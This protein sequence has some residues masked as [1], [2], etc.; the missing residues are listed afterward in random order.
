MKPIKTFGFVALAALLAMAFIG[1][2]SAVAEETSLCTIDENPCP[3]ANQIT[4]IHLVTNGKIIVLSSSLNVECDALYLGPALRIIVPGYIIIH[5]L[6][7]YS[8]CNNS[9]TVTEEN[10]P[11]EI[12]VLKEGHE[13]AKVT[14]EV[15][16]HLV[17]SGFINCR[18]NGVGLVGTA[19]GPLLSTN[20]LN[21]HTIFSEKTINKESGS[22]CPSTGKL[23]LNLHPLEHT[24]ITS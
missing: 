19:V 23:D 21:G 8:N 15:L 2:S 20:L 11:A 3:E 24:Y 18:Y 22:L 12:E 10:G 17:C 7:T 9:C 4:H 13:T 6:A 1:A 16:V 5:L 14:G